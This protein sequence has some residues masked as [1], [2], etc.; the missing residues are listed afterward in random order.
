MLECFDARI[1]NSTLIGY[2]LNFNL[3]TYYSI[4]ALNMVFM[5]KFGVGVNSETYN[6]IE[7][8]K[9]NRFYRL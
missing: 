5:N 4:P 2:G 8:W 9:G 1:K 3:C 6:P 7:K